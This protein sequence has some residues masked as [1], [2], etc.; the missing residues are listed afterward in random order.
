MSIDSHDPL[1]ILPDISVAD[2]NCIF[3][4]LYIGKLNTMA[5][6]EIYILYRNMP[7]GVSLQIIFTP[8]IWL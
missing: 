2:M 3:A 5:S 6:I 4:V 1:Q 8:K 7:L